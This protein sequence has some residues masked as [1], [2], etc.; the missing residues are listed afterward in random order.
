M[1]Y[2]ISLYE[3]YIKEFIYFFLLHV[4][5]VKTYIHGNEHSLNSDSEN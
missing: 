3:L 5:I 2:C 1:C 4:N